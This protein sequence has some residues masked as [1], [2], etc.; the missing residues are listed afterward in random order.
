MCPPELQIASYSIGNVFWNVYLSLFCRTSGS[1][2]KRVENGSK[3]T[4]VENGSTH[5]AS[6]GPA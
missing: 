4:R 3:G 5:P 6:L 2:G 1:K